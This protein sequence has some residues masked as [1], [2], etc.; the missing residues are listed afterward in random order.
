MKHRKNKYNHFSWF[1]VSI[2]TKCDFYYI[3]F[4]TFV[5]CW[6]SHTCQP[7]MFYSKVK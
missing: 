2:R 1:F 3:L 6:M 4:K 7:L 5:I